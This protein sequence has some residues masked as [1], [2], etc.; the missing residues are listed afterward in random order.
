[1]STVQHAPPV[2]RKHPQRVGFVCN[3]PTKQLPWLGENGRNDRRVDAE[4][5][6]GV[7]TGRGT[8]FMHSEQGNEFASSSPVSATSGILPE[9]SPGQ[10]PATIGV[11]HKWILPCITFQESFE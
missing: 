8:A 4:N 7:V 3:P 1:M 6:R 11:V 5:H 2:F 9:Q 10:Q